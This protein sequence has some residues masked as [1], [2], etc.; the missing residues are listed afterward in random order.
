MLVGYSSPFGS[1]SRTRVLLALS[2]MGE[3]FARELSRLLEIPLNSVQGALRG[4]ER[5]GLVVGRTVGRNRMFCLNPGYFALPELRPY[6]D[7]LARADSRLT[8]A[9]RATRRRPR[10]TGKPL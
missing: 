6:L 10:R 2:E 3:S 8:V 4:L 7:R 9:L 1:A 5:D